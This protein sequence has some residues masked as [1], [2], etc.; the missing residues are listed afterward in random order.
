MTKTVLVV[1]IGAV[2]V[3]VGAAVLVLVAA[4]N[5]ISVVSC[6][7]SLVV[8][9]LW[10]LISQVSSQSQNR[11]RFNGDTAEEE[12]TIISDRPVLSV[13]IVFVHPV[14]WCL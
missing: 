14:R 5:G 2:V 11:T 8:F 6:A 13:W 12:S 1:T 7:S 10:L 9:L 4:N 3:V